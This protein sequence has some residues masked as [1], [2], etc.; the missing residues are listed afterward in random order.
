[1]NEMREKMRDER[2]AMRGAARDLLLGT[3]RNRANANAH[4]TS[5]DHRHVNVN[6]TRGGSDD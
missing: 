4:Q 5:I 1:M 2:D 3:T 6:G